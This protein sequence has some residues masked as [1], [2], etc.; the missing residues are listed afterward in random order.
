MP[1]TKTLAE[2]RIELAKQASIDTDDLGATILR[3]P[4]TWVNL[5]LNDSYRSLRDFVVAHGFK[6]YKVA[7]TAT[8]FPTTP[9]VAGETYAEI[10]WPATAVDILGVDA[11]VDSSAGWWP[12]EP[13]EWEERRMFDPAPFYANGAAAPYAFSPISQGSVSGAVFTAG[14]IAVFPIPN[15]G[16]YKI[17]YL[18]EWVNITNDTHLFLFGNEDWA[19][20]ML[21]EATRRIAT[22]DNDSQSRLAEATRQLNPLAADTVAY[23]IVQ[24]APKHVKAGPMTWRRAPDY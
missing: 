21:W 24:S 19:Q 20:W 14:T 8:A 15:T 12:L 22:R 6:L 17:W 10:P 11:N 2:M 1:I 7:T 16:L 13:V 23:R 9:P 3:H 4:S 5:V 18:P